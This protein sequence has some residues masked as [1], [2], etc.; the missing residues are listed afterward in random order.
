MTSHVPTGFPALP[1][2]LGDK[3]QVISF[4]CKTCSLVI[5]GPHTQGQGEP[6]WLP[7]L[8]GGGFQYPSSSRG[9]SYAGSQARCF[10]GQR[11]ICLQRETWGRDP[12]PPPHSLWRWTWTHGH[13]LNSCLEPGHRYQDLVN[14][15]HPV[16][17]SKERMHLPDRSVGFIITHSTFL[18]KKKSPKHWKGNSQISH[19]GAKGWKVKRQAAEAKGEEVTSHITSP[20]SGSHRANQTQIWRRFNNWGAFW[21]DY[22]LLHNAASALFETFNSNIQVRWASLL[23]QR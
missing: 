15:I 10:S 19:L 4:F 8:P 2:T 17:F 13:I 22:Q 14:H 18:K 9:T 21:K 1:L 11:T 23:A 7:Q 12:Q 3:E 5:T 20:A 16:I 6:V